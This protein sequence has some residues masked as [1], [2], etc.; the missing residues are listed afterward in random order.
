LG[1]CS[2]LIRVG[3]RGYIEVPS[4][5]WESC[6]GVERPG[7]VGLSHHRWLIDIQEN[8]V[9][10][11]QKYQMIHSHWRFSLPQSHVRS[12]S[13]ERAVQWLWWDESFTFDEVTIHGTG[14]LE[15]ELERFVRETR[16]YP[17]WQLAADKWFRQAAGIA[18]RVM[19]RL[20]QAF[21]GKA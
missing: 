17:K 13:P 18:S 21:V 12:M 7:L 4:R 8:H 19:N 5:E 1:V 2:E 16:P 20:G 15:A 9:R 11:F 6:R 10:F 3:K 14:N